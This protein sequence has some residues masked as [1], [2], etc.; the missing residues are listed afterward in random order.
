MRCLGP[1]SDSR[2][3]VGPSGSVERGSREAPLQA[4]AFGAKRHVEWSGTGISSHEAHEETKT[5]APGCRR[6]RGQLG[7]HLRRP[8]GNPGR[9]TP[10]NGYRRWS[11][12]AVRREADYAAGLARRAMRSAPQPPGTW[13]GPYPSRP[14][15][16]S[17]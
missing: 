3:R 15:S 10:V 2:R 12:A 13:A 8:S 4:V 16:A 17:W 14:S 6:H 1:S 11:M 7:R 5:R 9:V